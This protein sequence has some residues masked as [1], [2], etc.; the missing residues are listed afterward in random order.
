MREG[1]AMRPFLADF[2]ELSNIS[3]AEYL[4]AQALIRGQIEGAIQM[5]AA[6][7]QHEDEAV[8]MAVLRGCTS[9]KP[10]LLKAMAIDTLRDEFPNTTR[11]IEATHGN[12]V[13][14]SQPA[15]FSAN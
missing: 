7:E 9:Y 3:F 13:G 10:V 15:V 1:A 2:N 14:I 4:V 6:I 5:A 12:N 8:F 11:L